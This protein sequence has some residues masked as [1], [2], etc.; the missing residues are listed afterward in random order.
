MLNLMIEIGE[1]F[2]QRGAALFSSRSC[3]SKAS[4][5]KLQ[6]ELCQ[7]VTIG[8]GGTYSSA[9]V[10]QTDEGLIGFFTTRVAGGLGKDVEPPDNH[11]V[12]LRPDGSLRVAFANGPWDSVKDE[13][14]WQPPE[15]TLLRE[16]ASAFKTCVKA[17]SPQL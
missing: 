10:H 15:R 13:L 7:S 9:Q 8:V 5:R 2:V 1:A 12:L 16:I 17:N 4:L 6:A 14:L 11:A 3:P